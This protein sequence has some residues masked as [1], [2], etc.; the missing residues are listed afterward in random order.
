MDL[1]NLL[2]KLYL[3]EHF[4]PTAFVATVFAASVGHFVDKVM[5][6]QSFG[7]VVNTLVVLLAIAM[8]ASMTNAR[9][10]TL[11]PDDT[12][13]ISL[14]AT[15]AGCGMLLMTASLRRWLRDYM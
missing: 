6:K 10:H 1:G 3:S 8:G 2:L 15:F 5:D 14:V 11:F 13:R 9:V 4:L 12:M 7:I